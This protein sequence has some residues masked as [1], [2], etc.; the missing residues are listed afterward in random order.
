[1]Q[2]LIQSSINHI[3]I[4]NMIFH[5]LL[6]TD[7]HSHT[8]FMHFPTL[9]WWRPTN[10]ENIFISSSLIYLLTNVD[11]WWHAHRRHICD[12]YGTFVSV[13]VKRYSV[14]RH[15]I[16]LYY[17]DIIKKKNPFIIHTNSRLRIIVILLLYYKN[18][19][20]FFIVRSSARHEGG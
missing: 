20:S 13:E 19:Y 5:F 17:S 9:W 3:I 6:N 11:W 18:F 7:S 15:R 16:A 12:E 1:M 8:L 2:T 4:R 10:K 14:A